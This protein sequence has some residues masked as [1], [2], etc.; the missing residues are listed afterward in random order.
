M[1]R[2]IVILAVA[3]VFVLGLSTVSWAVAEFDFGASIRTNIQWNQTNDDFEEANGAIGDDGIGDFNINMANGGRS[4]IYMNGTLDDFTARLEIRLWEGNEIR[5]DRASATWDFAEGMYFLFGYDSD[6]VDLHWSDAVMDNNANYGFGAIGDNKEVQLQIGGAT[7]TW[8]WGICIAEPY[9]SGIGAGVFNDEHQ[10]I[11]RIEGI[12]K[13]ALGEMFDI[14]FSAWY[15][16]SE[17]TNGGAVSDEDV[18]EYGINGRF[19]YFSE[20]VNVGVGGFYGQNLGI[21]GVSGHPGNTDAAGGVQLIA[22]SVEDVDTYGLFATLSF[23][24]EPVTLGIGGGFETAD[25]DAASTQNLLND[26]WTQWNFYV[27]VLYNFTDNFFIIPEFLWRDYGEDYND[28]DQGNEW[29]L[30]ARLQADF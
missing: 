25:S 10:Y 27:N 5:T 2:K 17:M 18:D 20:F 3:A 29:V 28:I 13:W 1:M 7:E 4:R 22:N 12:G 24:I 21:S 23:P 30:G 9:D 14:G 16:T 8:S 15:Q 19:R 11:P 26:D 6:L